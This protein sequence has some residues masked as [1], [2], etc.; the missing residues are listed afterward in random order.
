MKRLL[1]AVLILLILSIG[2]VGESARATAT[3]I[4]DLVSGIILSS[5][6]SGYV[7]APMVTLTGGGGSGAMAKAFLSGD[8]VSSVVVLSAGRGYTS[9]P[10]VVIEEPPRAFAFKIELVPK[11]SVT[12]P[13]GSGARFEFAD[14]LSGEWNAWTNVSV[15]HEGAVLV[16]LQPGNAERFYRAEPGPAGFVWI[17]PGI[18]VMGSPVDEAFRQPDETQHTVQLTRGFWMSDHEVT[19]SEYQSVIGNNPSLFKGD[20]SLPVDTVSWEDAV[21]YCEKLTARE[22]A[23]GRITLQQT[24]RLPTEAEWEYA[25]RAGTSEPWYAPFE[26]IAWHSGNSLNATHPVKQKKP[27]AWGLHDM[28]GNVWEWCS[29]WYG[30]Y[31]VGSATDPKGPVSGSLRVLRGG[32]WIDDAKICRA[33]YRR[34]NM[35]THRN[36]YGGFRPVLSSAR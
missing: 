17:S 31:P 23:A 13:P 33:A 1:S 8:R 35:V 36:K 12:G 16:D 22:R 24:F 27:N 19:Q 30:G 7:D 3:I 10:I 26:G 2:A 5:S 25:A 21:I 4:G 28:I 6:G 34:A 32:C 9:A 11:I 20:L 15:G 29:D 14:G 18:L